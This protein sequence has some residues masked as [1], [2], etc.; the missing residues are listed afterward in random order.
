MIKA[1][2]FCKDAVPSPQGW[3][4][5]KNNELLKSQ[6]ISQAEIDEWNGNTPVAV[7]VVEE[8]VL[9]AEELEVSPPVAVTPPSVKKTG[10]KRGIGSRIKKAVNKAKDEVKDTL[11]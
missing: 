1:P 8:P 6:R 10:A 9:Q 2:K 4:H 7:E 11:D 5:P 3:R